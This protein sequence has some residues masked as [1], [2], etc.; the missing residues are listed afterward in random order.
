MAMK[1]VETLAA[2]TRLQQA[3]NKLPAETAEH[4]RAA[5]WFALRCLNETPAGAGM[6]PRMMLTDPRASQAVEVVERWLEAGATYRQLQDAAER[7]L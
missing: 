4:A 6:T 5:V 2:A 7:A 1:N 3:L